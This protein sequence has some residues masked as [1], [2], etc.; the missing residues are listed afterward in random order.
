MSFDPNKNPEPAD[1]SF[2]VYTSVLIIIAALVVGWIFYSRHQEDRAIEQRAAARQRAT[3]RASY[4]LLGGDRF[5]ILAFYTNPS[6]VHRG[7]ETRVCYAVSN[8]KSVSVSPP[9][10]E[11]WPSYGR[12]MQ[13]N[14]KKTT[15]Y[16]LRIED[17]AGHSKTATTKVDVE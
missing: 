12:C 6:S 15:T 14:P 10:G 1:R 8:A 5:A 11:V 13:V 4:R 16:T 7:D 3:D 2:L 17:G 9:V